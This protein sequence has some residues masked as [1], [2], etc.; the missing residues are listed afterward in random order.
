MSWTAKIC[1][2]VTGKFLIVLSVKADGFREAEERAIAKACLALRGDPKLM[3]VTGL[4][5]F[6]ER[7][8]A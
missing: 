6:H 8:L 2:K 5:G 3:D 1:D 4:H 7:R